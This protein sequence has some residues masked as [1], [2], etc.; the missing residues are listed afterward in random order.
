M[1]NITVQQCTTVEKVA[2]VLYQRIGVCEVCTVM[3]RYSLTHVWTQSKNPEYV[4]VLHRLR[5]FRSG[6]VTPVSPIIE[7][8]ILAPSH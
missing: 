6:T 5:S 7:I 8:R 1:D 4:T 2:P 3:A